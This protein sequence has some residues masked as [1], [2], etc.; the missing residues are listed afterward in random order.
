MPKIQIRLEHGII[1]S[2]DGLPE[3]AIDVPDDDIDKYENAALSADENGC[4][5]E[6]KEWHAPE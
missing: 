2:I 5:C 3:I 4:A 6:I 1:R